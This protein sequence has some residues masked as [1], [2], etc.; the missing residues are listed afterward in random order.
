MSTEQDTRR[1][2]ETY[3]DIAKETSPANLDDKVMAMARQ[4]ARTRYGLA[5]AWIRPVAWAATIGLN[6]AFI[7]EM[8]YFSDDA[9]PVDASIPASVDSD[10]GKDA[11]PALEAPAFKRAPAAVVAAP[12]IKANE[13]PALRE[14]E[15]RA[16]AAAA[17]YAEDVPA[18]QLRRERASLPLADTVDHCDAEDRNDADSW[19]RCVL[20][21]RERG[22]D[23][24][25]DA[26]LD[27]LREAFPDFR[28][29]VPE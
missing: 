5:R 27:A 17:S 8:T 7:L 3:R 19:Y 21:L 22:L 15:E 11:D 26:E 20:A 28:E 16:D 29:P 4:E 10:A 9:P 2:S 13:A 1:V 14:A 24:A 23:E 6:F 12:E 25:A 18:A